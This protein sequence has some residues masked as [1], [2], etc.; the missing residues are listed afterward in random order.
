M[1]IRNTLVFLLFTSKIQPWT[2]GRHRTFPSQIQLAFRTLVLSLRRLQGKGQLKEGPESGHRLGIGAAGAESE[3][4]SG[5][6]TTLSEG[7][8]AAQAFSSSPLLPTALPPVL[9]PLVHVDPAA[10]E[11][12]LEGVKRGEKWSD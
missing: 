11:W 1:S 7:A 3:I 10:I 12:I 2:P 6:V 8:A 5:T 4:I 9:P